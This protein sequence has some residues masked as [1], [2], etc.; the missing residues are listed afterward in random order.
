MQLPLDEFLN[1]RAQSLA[2]ALPNARFDFAKLFGN[3]AQANFITLSDLHDMQ[4]TL[5]KTPEEMEELKTHISQNGIPGKLILTL[6]EDGKIYVRDGRHRLQALRDLGI[7]TLPFEN[8]LFEE[9]TYDDFS[10]IRFFED[11]NGRLDLIN[12]WITPFDPRLHHRQPQLTPYKKI[13][14]LFYD[15]GIPPENIVN[16]IV[17]HPELYRHDIVSKNRPLSTRDW[18]SYIAKMQAS[19]PIKIAQLLTLLPTKGVMVDVGCGSGDQSEAYA[20]LFRDLIVMGLDMAPESIDFAQANFQSRENLI[21]MLANVC[22]EIFPPDTIAGFIAGSVEHEIFS[23]TGFNRD[24]LRSFYR[25]VV[26]ALEPGGKYGAR[27]FIA[28]R[29]PKKVLLKLPKNPESLPGDFGKLSRSELFVNYAQN[30]TSADY[31]NGV[32]YTKVGADNSDWDTYEL[33]GVA[34]ANFMLR[35]EY[36]VNWLAELKEQYLYFTLD[37]KIRELEAAGLRVDY[38]TEIDNVWIWLNW[39]KGRVFVTDTDGNK[40]DLPPTSSIFHTTKPGPRDPKK[41][42]IKSAS[43]TET[44]SAIQLESFRL[45]NATSV[46]DVIHVPGTTN[47]TLPYEVDAEGKIWVYTQDKSEEPA[48]RYYSETSAMG[49]AHYSGY[50]YRGISKTTDSAIQSA[51]YFSSP[52]ISDEQVSPQFIFLNNPDESLKNAS[53]LKR[54]SLNELLSSCLLG[55]MQDARVEEALYRL[56]RQRGHTFLPWSDG[57]LPSTDQSEQISTA[58]TASNYASVQNPSQTNVFTTSETASGFSQITHLE[59]TRVWPDGR[60][61]DFSRDYLE[62]KVLGSETSSVVPY[63]LSRGEVF[64]GLEKRQLASVQ[65]KIGSADIVVT[66]AWRLPK[67]VKSRVQAN[68]FLRERMQADFNLMSLNVTP[69]GAG[70]F[71]SLTYMPER[72]SPFAVEVDLNH[73]PRDLDFVPLKSLL[74]DIENI[75][76]LHTRILILRLAHAMGALQRD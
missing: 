75:P 38:A 65:H 16:F 48:L 72:V 37:E 54:H 44:S 35:M 24:S 73:Q 45:A 76:E 39:F 1:A 7:Q 22:E 12:S 9:Y 60:T 13:I 26:K 18:A 29:W 68:L 61:E 47:F 42:T 63:F 53:P 59:M 21:F 71:P 19:M 17:Q 15:H 70:Y 34:A 46:F 4:G 10:E 23:Y 3:R 33:D 49:T 64:I 31:P 32:P 50:T 51:W 2:T 25:A 52:G 40:I 67:H 66:P 36:R 8:C 41:L 27:D 6:F 56:A 5:R 28:P 62:P 14:K 43:P 69:L 74:E 58:T 20:R 30:F 11:E 57:K 55:G